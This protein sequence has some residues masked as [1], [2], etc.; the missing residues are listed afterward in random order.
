MTRSYENGFVCLRSVAWE[1]VLFADNLFPVGRKRNVVIL[2]TQND[3]MVTKSDGQ[4]KFAGFFVVV[5]FMYEN[6]TY[7]NIP[8]P[9]T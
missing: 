7:D 6:S 1:S 9:A 3:N 5:N 2:R 4:V 8:R